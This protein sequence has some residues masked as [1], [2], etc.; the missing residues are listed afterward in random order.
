MKKEKYHLEY[1]FDRVSQDSLW[2]KLSTE[3]GL[4]EWFADGVMIEG[5]RIHF[6]WSDEDCSSA[7]ISEVRSGE[8]IRF[9]WEDDPGT[10]MEF[11]IHTTEL[12]GSR[13]LEITDFAESVERMIAIG[14]WDKQIDRLKHS[15][16][17][18]H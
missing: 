10:Y 12:T 16:G 11:C 6:C 3:D 9:D 15:L 18:Q 17:V 8:A 14:L 2:R 1:V 4:V 5:D 13:S 7:T